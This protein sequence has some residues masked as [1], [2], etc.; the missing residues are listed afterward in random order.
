MMRAYGAPAIGGHRRVETIRLRALDTIDAVDQARARWTQLCDVH[1]WR[2][3]SVFGADGELL[4]Y[5]AGSTGAGGQIRE[6]RLAG[7][8][9]RPAD[10]A[11]QLGISRASAYRLLST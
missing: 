6:L 9:V 4:A 10:I 1:D 2:A 7:E 11:V 5:C 8:G 3:Y